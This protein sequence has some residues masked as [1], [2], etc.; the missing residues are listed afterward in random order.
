MVGKFAKLKKTKEEMVKYCIRKSFKFITSK[1]RN[2]EKEAFVNMENSEVV[3]YY[4]EKHAEGDTS[5]SL[6]FQYPFLNYAENPHRK[7]R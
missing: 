6:P 1:M 4:F 2:E 5:I 7:K 3:A